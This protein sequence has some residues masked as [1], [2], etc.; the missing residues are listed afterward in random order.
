MVAAPIV[1]AFDVGIL[2]GGRGSRLGGADKAWLR[3]DGVAQVERLAAAFSGA[4]RVLVSANREPQR[5]AGLGLPVV[6]DRFADAGPLG[7]LEALAGACAVDWLLTVPVDA[8]RLPERLAERLF[9]CGERGAWVVD[10]DG[11][12]PLVALWPLARLRPALG[13][14]LRS[15]ERAVHALQRRIGM[16]PLRLPGARLGNLNT[17]ADLAAAGVRLP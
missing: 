15:H 8:V 9:A 14:A 6:P 4:G 3:R 17:P 12:Q 7:G 11:P 2:A 10:D 5:Y 13:A 1:R 16:T